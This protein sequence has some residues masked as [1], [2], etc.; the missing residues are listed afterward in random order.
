MQ[1]HKAA[2]IHLGRNGQSRG[3]T[4]NEPAGVGALLPT[5]ARGNLHCY[6]PHVSSSLPRMSR[7]LFSLCS[8]PAMCMPQAVITYA[9]CRL[10]LAACMGASSR[11]RTVKSARELNPLIPLE[12]ASPAA[13][14]EMPSPLLAVHSD[15]EPQIENC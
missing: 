14:I 12:A 4:A 1:P 5:Y 15:N 3:L 2:A 13:A 8:L 11:G 9:V 6:T 7:P 10:P